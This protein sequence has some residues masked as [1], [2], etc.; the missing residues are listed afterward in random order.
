MCLSL[1]VHKALALLKSLKEEEKAV[2]TVESQ[3]MD[4]F[5]R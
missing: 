1:T 5:N 4:L 3:E 2:D